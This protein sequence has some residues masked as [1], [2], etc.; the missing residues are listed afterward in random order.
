[1]TMLRWDPWSEVAAL[2]RDVSE[3]MGRTASSGA[4]GRGRSPVPALDAF[5]DDDGLTVAVELPGLRPDDVEITVEDGVLTL[6]GERRMPDVADDAWVRRERAVGSFTRSFTLP[7]GTDPDAI[8][9]AFEH[10]VLSLRIPH[11]PARKPRRIQI[12]ATDDREALDLG[13]AE[14]KESEARNGQE[15]A[16]SNA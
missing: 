3:L 14:A 4:V 11:P 15:M 13:T 16:G 7:E 10:G 9:A 6:S 2:Q 8:S 5:R 12:A 1:M